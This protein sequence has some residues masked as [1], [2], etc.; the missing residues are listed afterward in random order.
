MAKKNLPHILSC[1]NLLTGAVNYRTASGWSE[2]FADAH[3]F[4]D[5]D[6]AAA[7]R[8][9]AGEFVDAEPHAVEMTAQGVLPLERRE[10]IKALGPTVRTDLGKQAELQTEYALAA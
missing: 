7:V 5:F 4:A 2:Q 10:R 9:P 3:V 8:V 1:N 6:S